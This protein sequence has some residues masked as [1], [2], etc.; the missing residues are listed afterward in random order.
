MQANLKMI[1]NMM[2][3]SPMMRMAF[4]RRV[5]Q[6]FWKKVSCQQI[7]QLCLRKWWRNFHMTRIQIYIRIYYNIYKNILKE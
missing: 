4:S 2:K 6:N 3:Q 7:Y 5:S 1:M